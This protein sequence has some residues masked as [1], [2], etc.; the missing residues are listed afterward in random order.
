MEKHSDTPLR[1]GG[2]VSRPVKISGDEPKYTSL[3]RRAGIQG[4]VIIEAIIDEQGNVTSQNILQG[5]PMGL[6]GAARNAVRTWKFR[7]A[8]FGGQPV[9]VFYILH[10]HFQT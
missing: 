3:A 5:L 6:D 1:V 4:E 9:K 7:P 2:A 8:M 10:V